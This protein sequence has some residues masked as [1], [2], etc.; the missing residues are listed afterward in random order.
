MGEWLAL[1][2]ARVPEARCFV[3]EGEDRVLTFGEENRRVNR[4]AQAL[5]DAGARRGDR[6]ALLDVDSFRYMETLLASMKL[7]TVYVPLNVRLVPDELATLLTAAE[8]TWLYVGPRYAELAAEL[9]DRVPSL[10][11]VVAFSGP[12]RDQIDYEAFLAGG[13]EAEPPSL[14]EDEDVVGLAFTSGTTGRP[15]GVLQSHRMMKTMVVNGMVCLNTTEDE[16]RYSAAP[17]FHIGGMAMLMHGIARGFPNLLLPQFEAEAALR[18]MQGGEI[19]SVFLVPTMV[20]RLLAVPGVGDHDYSRLRSIVYGGAPMTPS[21]LRRALEVFNCD[22]IQVFAAGTEAGGQT[23]LDAEDHRRALAGE[24]HLLA[25]VGRPTFGVALRL[26]DD[27]MR[28]VAPGQ[29]GEIATRS[30]SVMSGYLAHPAESARALRDGWFRAG[31]LAWAD[32]EGYLYLS[33]R[34]SDMIIRG[35]ENVYPIEIETVLADFPGVRDVAVIG[36]EDE[37]WGES[38]CAV[39]VMDDGAARPSDVE[40]RQHCRRSLAAYKCPVRFEFASSLPLNASGKVLKTELRS[41]YA[42]RSSSGGPPG[43][44]RAR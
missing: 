8:P 32:D 35:G 23:V 19:T 38:V 24:E 4:L 34:T 29:V 30:D 31:D 21:L 13:S 1:S 22:F 7:G 44:D 6:L 12:G 25:S 28:D 27:D 5:G 17:L 10:R 20:N 43:D 16:F 2:A 26:V 18:W 41:T 40:L 37:D 11:R 36:L 14:V 9:A 39:V 15:K 33:G 3:D 42:A